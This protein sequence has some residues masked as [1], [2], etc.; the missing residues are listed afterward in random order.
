MENLETRLHGE[1]AELGECVYIMNRVV[2]V[3]IG[4]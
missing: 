2:P 1:K 3:L 4:W